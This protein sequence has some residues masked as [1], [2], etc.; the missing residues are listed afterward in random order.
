MR[1]AVLAPAIVASTRLD[2]RADADDWR[3]ARHPHRRWGLEFDE[4]GIAHRS[5][6]NDR[7]DEPAVRLVATVSR[8][9][10]IQQSQVRRVVV[11]PDAEHLGV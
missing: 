1:V 3:R 9:S 10:R 4:R 7:G 11:A 5:V 2:P 6:I 8:G